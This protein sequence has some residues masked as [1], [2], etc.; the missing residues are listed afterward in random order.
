MN[1]LF[2][3][4]VVLFF[5]FS[6]LLAMSL[7]HS[8][9]VMEHINPQTIS[10][11]SYVQME[12]TSPEVELRL[13]F[14]VRPKHTNTLRN[15]LSDVSDRKPANNGENMAKSPN[16]DA[17]LAEN[18]GNH[19]VKEYL[20]RIGAAVSDESH[21]GLRI[22]ASAHAGIWEQAL[23]CTFNTFMRVGDNEKFIRTQEYALPTHVAAHVESVINT[24]QLPLQT[25]SMSENARNTHLRSR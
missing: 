10:S 6:L 7:E 1:F 14:V 4:I 2:A 17:M 23:R 15:I 8:H 12:R 24:V 25:R 11:G 13:Q 3:L 20:R 19:V 16:A 21:D 18:D 5:T 9:R 22:T